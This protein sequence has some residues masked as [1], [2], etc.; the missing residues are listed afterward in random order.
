MSMEQEVLRVLKP[1][2]SAFPTMK[3]DAKAWPI[4]ARALSLQLTPDEV[5]AAMLKLLNTVKWFPTIAE[6][7]EAAKSIRET[8]EGSGLPSAGEAW[9]E[10][11]RQARM[12]GLDRPW[13]YSCHEVKIA[14]ERFGKTELMYLEESQTNTAR[15]QFMR[16]YTEVIQRQKTE[17]E[18]NAVLDALPNARAKLAQGK[19]IQLAEAKKVAGG[20]A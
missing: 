19:I 11:I 15:A 13:T 6:I 20:A 1:Y 12:N 2:A 7:I 16:I 10:I 17:R 9:E 8:A 18:N 3:V 14:L 5:N 4:Y